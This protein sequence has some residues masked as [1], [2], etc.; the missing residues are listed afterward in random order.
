MP[1]YKGGRPIRD[2][3]SAS[4]ENYNRFH[5]ENP[6]IKITFKEYEAI[7]RTWNKKFAIHCLETGDK[8]MFP[9]GFGPIAVNRKKTERYFV[10]K[11]GIEHIILP[12]D[13]PATLDDKENP[14][15][16]KIYIMNFH[17]EGYRFNWFWFKNESKLRMSDVWVF[18]PAKS[19]K[20][21]L[22]TY[23]TNPTTKYYQR[24]REWYHRKISKPKANVL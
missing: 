12:V 22:T 2:Y 18:Q 21:L 7:I 1:K 11:D 4:K 23:L 10:D 3:R 20:N 14:E 6:T 5:L 24:Y 19:L 13:W 15:H 8:I 9:F 17:T 16:K